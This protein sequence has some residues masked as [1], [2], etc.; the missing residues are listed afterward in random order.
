M[1][2]IFYVCSVI[3]RWL[4]TPLV[5]VCVAI[6]FALLHWLPEGSLLA[7]KVDSAIS[8]LLRWWVMVEDYDALI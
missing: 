7:H 2:K 4:A 8:A 6:A 1:K 5:G 3:I